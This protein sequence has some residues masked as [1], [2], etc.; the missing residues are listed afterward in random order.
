MSHKI[1]NKPKMPKLL[2][3]LKKRNRAHA[4][5]HKGFDKVQKG[6]QPTIIYLGCADSR[7]F[8][9]IGKGFNEHFIQ[10]N[11]GNRIDDSM[12][13][14][15]I[16][17]AI[18]HIP[19]TGILYIIGHTGCGAIAGAIGDHS[20]EKEDL[21]EYLGTMNYLLKFKEI[22]EKAA[23]PKGIDEKLFRNSLYAEI[24]VDHQVK[25]AMKIY[26][27]MVNSGKVTII[28]G[29]YDLHGVYS[30]KKGLIHPINIE[31]I[32]TKEELQNHKFFK[33]LSHTPKVLRFT[34]Y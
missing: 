21:K 3:G 15:S 12:L 28:G 26:Q 20:N 17:Y 9:P 8:D 27:D 29:V 31:G 24:N 5:K 14:A 23:V 6:Q 25:H 7:V 19:E 30:D 16:T 32:I 4:E 11:A 13:S 10:R 2:N 1:D 22:V 34:Q 18:E 33:I